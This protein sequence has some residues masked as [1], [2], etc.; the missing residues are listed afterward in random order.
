MNSKSHT[1]GECGFNV[2][3][4]R[5]MRISQAIKAADVPHG[6]RADGSRYKTRE[7]KGDERAEAGR[8]VWYG[9]ILGT[10]ALIAVLSLGL[11]WVARKSWWGPDLD[12][13]AKNANIPLRIIEDKK[14]PGPGPF[15]HPYCTGYRVETKI[16]K[17]RIR[18]PKPVKAPSGGEGPAAW[19]AFAEAFQ[20]PMYVRKR[21]PE[22]MVRRVLLEKLPEAEGSYI[23]RKLERGVSVPESG[24]LVY[25]DAAAS[26]ENGFMTGFL[27]DVG[28]EEAAFIKELRSPGVNLSI[29]GTLYFIASRERDLSNSAYATAVREGYERVPPED[30]APAQ[31]KKTS[32]E[33]EAEESDYYFFHPVVR[34][35]LYSTVR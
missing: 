7:E 32:S 19:T 2:K 12:E 15:M 29:N 24:L 10:L 14:I 1:C 18:P 3:L 22:S 13:R 20:L 25:R 26:E 27:L 11:L 8:K 23:P 30:S 21:F 9:A 28:G 31:K 16:D 33:D 4:G 5:R 6:V 34:V 35:T 17:R